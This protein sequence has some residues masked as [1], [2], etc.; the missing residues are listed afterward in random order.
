MQDLE[1]V[2]KEEWSMKFTDIPL[3]QWDMRGNWYPN[4]NLNMSIADQRRH[5]I[6]GGHYPASN[7]DDYHMVCVAESN[8]TLWQKL[9]SWIKK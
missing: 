6:I 9:I 2:D 5:N 4:L 1:D 3:G 7:I 8:P